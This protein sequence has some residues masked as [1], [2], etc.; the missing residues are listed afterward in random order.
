[1][2]QEDPLRSLEE[3][4]ETLPAGTKLSFYFNYE[5]PHGLK[6]SI[7]IGAP[8]ISNQVPPDEP[9]AAGQGQIIRHITFHKPIKINSFYLYLFSREYELSALYQ[10]I[11][12][13]INVVK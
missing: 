3:L 6:T 13:N 5:L 2:A 4:P 8:G 10:R 11:P 9:D 7:R 12:C 1:M